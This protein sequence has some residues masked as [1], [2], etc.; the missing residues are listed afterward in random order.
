[1]LQNNNPTATASIMLDN[2][3]VPYTVNGMSYYY[4]FLNVPA[5]G[6]SGWFPPTPLILSPPFDQTL[7]S[8]FCFHTIVIYGDT[9]CCD[10]LCIELPNCDPCDNISVSTTS[11]STS[12][13]Q[14]ISITNNFLGNYFSGVSVVPISFGAS[15]ASTTLGVGGAGWASAGNS[16]I[17]SFYPPGNSTIPVGTI[18]DL[19]TLCLN[20]Q[21]GAAI[22]QIVVFNWFVPGA[23]GTD[24]VVCTDTLVFNC[25]PPLQNPCGEIKDSIVCLATE[26]I[27][28]PSLFSTTVRIQFQRQRLIT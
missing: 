13:C 26:H 18:T 14:Q 4:Q 15:I 19:F 2:F 28:T 24:S 10:S 22:P 25:D 5:N 7:P 16:S 1:M 17:M 9:C 6:N 21:I 8:T 11:D 27:N 3:T 12:C 20:L 23:D